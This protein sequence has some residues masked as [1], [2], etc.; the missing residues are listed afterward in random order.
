[1]RLDALSEGQIAYLAFVAMVELNPKRSVLVFDEPEVHLHPALLARVLFMFEDAAKRTPVV[2][3]THSDRLL[4]ALEDPAGTVVLCE[5]DERGATRLRRPVRNELDDWLRD[6]R[7]LGS[8]RTEGYEQHVFG[9]P[10]A[11]KRGGK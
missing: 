11:T 4:D 8:I 6:Y 3:S 9:E 10:T 7:G 1:L 2:L 5:L